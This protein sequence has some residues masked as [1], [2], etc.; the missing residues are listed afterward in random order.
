M[1]SGYKY[2]YI[3]IYTLHG[4]FLSLGWDFLGIPLLQELLYNT[5]LSRI[6]LHLPNYTILVRPCREVIFRVSLSDYWLRKATP[7]VVLRGFLLGVLLNYS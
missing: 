7:L 6:R 4:K 5:S 3:Y 1:A 2:I